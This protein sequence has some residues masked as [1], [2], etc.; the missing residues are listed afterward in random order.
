MYLNEGS[1]TFCE[2]E[3]KYFYTKG[4]NKFPL[5][6]LVSFKTDTFKEG[7]IQTIPVEMYLYEDSDEK[8]NKRQL[9]FVKADGYFDGTIYEASLKTEE[10]EKFAVFS[11]AVYEFLKLKL[12][13]P[14][15]L[16][17]VQISS[18]SAL[19][20]IKEPDGIMLNDWQA[21]PIAALAR[22]RAPMENAYNQL[23]DSAAEKLKNMKIATIGH[24]C[25][26]QGSTQN[27]NNEQKREAS[28]NILNTLFDKYTNDIVTNAKTGASATD[29]RDKGLVNLDNALIL[30]YN[31]PNTN[32]VNFLN[33]GIVLSDFFLPVSKNYALE[34]IDP[35]KNEL[36]HSLQWALVQKTKSERMIG[37][38]NGNDYKNLNMEAKI[39]QI[40]KTTGIDFTS[41]NKNSS[42]K[43][44]IQARK[45]NKFKLYNDYM[46][47]ATSAKGVKSEKIDMVKDLTSSIEF[48]K[49]KNDLS[50]P[51]ISKKTFEKT[52]VL[53]VVGRL[54]SQK[55]IDIAVDSI[56]KLYKNWEKEFPN[57]EKPIIYFAGMDN[58]GGKQRKKIEELIDNKLSKEDAS[59]IVFAHGFVPI[60]A[61]MAGSDFFLM[62]SKF[63]PC[64]LTQGEAMAVATPVIASAVGGIVDTV[65]R[66]N[67]HT[68]ILTDKNKELSANEFYKAISDGLKIYFEDKKEYEKMVMDSLSEDFSWI[69]KGKNGPVYDYLELFGIKRENLPDIE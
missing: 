16:K 33:M 34:L 30:N 45:E 58:E 69:Q 31:N 43:E 37:I 28:N 62:P 46:L 12:D 47:P 29:K 52:P 23:S 3:G 56:A 61:I 48:Y 54:V 42:K 55:G 8:N 40:K 49:G 68:G 22:Y 6:K 10:S 5:E 65:N 39:P 24:N 14:K 25:T 18:A 13:S 50:L 35:N 32:S 36:S 11:K 53:S 44:V 1:S 15:A 2:T 17:D 7:K 51:L 19:E 27:H 21:S 41:Y 9:V 26:Y 38:I 59:R 57:Q 20:K 66:G 4:K 67:K 64:G 63:E 60:N